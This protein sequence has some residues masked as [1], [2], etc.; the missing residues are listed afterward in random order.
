MDRAGDTGDPSGHFDRPSWPYY[1]TTTSRVRPPVGSGAGLGGSTAVDPFVG[2][3]DELICLRAE[4]AEAAAGRPRLVV[5]E[6]PA[7]IGK[8]RLIEFFVAA[9]EGIVLR[10]A[11]PDETESKVPYGVVDQWLSSDLG[12]RRATPGMDPVAVGGLLLDLVGQLEKD[13]AVVLLIDDAHWADLPSLQAVLFCFRRLQVDNVLVLLA[14]RSEEAD[15]LP[16][17]VQRLVS[18]GL[19]QRVILPGLNAGELAQIANWVGAS[20]VSSLQM[21]RLVEH[22]QGNPLYATAL[23]REMTPE[24]L[25][26]PGLPLPAPRLFAKATTARLDRC[27]DSARRLVQAVAVTG[28]VPLSVAAG[29]AAI[30]DPLGAVDEA[31]AGGLLKRLGVPPAITVRPAH[32]LV[33]AAVCQELP[34]SEQAR[35]HL[36]AA[37]LVPDEFAGIQH[38]IAASPGADERLAAE[39]AE[40]ARRQSRRGAAGLAAAALIGGARV[41]QRRATREQLIL[42]AIE[43][44]L[45]A[46]DV[47]T[48]AELAADLD[49]FP[50]TARRDWV[51]GWLALMTGAD[52]RAEQ[53]LIAAWG[54]A[55]ADEPELRR[56]IAVRLAEL[57]MH[58]ARGEEFVDWAHRA[59]AHA[60]A[61]SDPT[62]TELGVLAVG[63][64]ICGR[65]AEAFA[66]VDSAAGSGA[67][68]PDQIDATYGR[69]LIRALSDD[70]ADARED[71]RAVVEACRRS[72]GSLQLMHAL[73]LL[74][75]T[76]FRGGWWDDA[77]LHGELA[78]S[79]A[80]DG[81][82]MQFTPHV[83]SIAA[84]VH[85]R[86]GDFAVAEERIR[87]ALAASAGPGNESALGYAATAAAILGHSR[88]DHAAVVEATDPLMPL[89]GRI[90]VQHPFMV[91]W[92]ELRIEAL[93]RLG[94]LA[95]A[96]S[97]LASY[98]ER[99]AASGSHSVQANAARVH[100]LLAAASGRTD[101][102]AEAFERALTHSAVVD[103]PFERALVHLQYGA[104]LR[105]AGTRGVAA[106]HLRG[107]EEI[108][109][110]LGARPFVELA[111]RELAGCGLSRRR[112]AGPS[113]LTAQERT[114]AGLVG[115]GK[116]NREV[117]GELFISVK[118]V[119][120]HL[121]HI[122][123]KLGLRSRG[124]LIAHLHSGPR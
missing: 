80:E 87:A 33:G 109:R 31:V 103:L 101:E 60:K 91:R 85:A 17:S 79:L 29:V 44:S 113:P 40:Y 26:A 122:Y 54:Q 53:L 24:E 12:G 58:H 8:T 14:V 18:A 39:I 97:L 73:A 27:S 32:P 21:R 100:G 34:A 75:E 64:F 116:S 37:T 99:C 83:S 63:L 106:E 46:A 65:K 49:H 121:G 90:G 119:E 6:G 42:E 45:V 82:V 111:G 20:Q 67:L 102:A 94:R 70:L 98:A 71:L 66:L 105:R 112:A 1:V 9:L 11:L 92:Q 68:R 117:A 78:V 57:L 95:E 110:R 56:K 61:S 10:R 5:V 74:S 89:L 3:A 114:V 47:P 41:A 22:T 35:L 13:S 81:D 93:V 19:G 16:D 59:V 50:P 120:Y 88:G 28:A 55:P 107:A 48:A 30:V 72:G 115:T 25:G 69:G 123:A 124:Q 51:A 52:D 15:R 77:H 76:E 84:Q 96:D 104:H 2:R 7:G 23:L 62:L 118:T 108:F 36:A 38:R 86:R 43:M 4:L